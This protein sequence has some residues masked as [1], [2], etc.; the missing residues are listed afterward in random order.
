MALLG[1]QG[2]QRTLSSR[3]ETGR[4]L[5]FDIEWRGKESGQRVGIE[6]AGGNRFDVGNRTRD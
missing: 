1:L 6:R 5:G 4:E 2:G 3:Q